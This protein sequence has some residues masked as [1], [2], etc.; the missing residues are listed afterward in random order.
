MAMSD[1]VILTNGLKVGDFLNTQGVYYAPYNKIK[2]TWKSDH[3]IVAHV[4]SHKQYWSHQAHNISAHFIVFR[5]VGEDEH[6]NWEVMKDWEKKTDRQFHKVKAE[7]IAHAE[8]IS[9]EA[10]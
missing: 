2:C 1:H 7:A 10:I 5:K 8:S 4:G 6:G 9:E 3:A